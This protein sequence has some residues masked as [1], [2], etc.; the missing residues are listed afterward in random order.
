MWINTP[1]P[2]NS[3]DEKK[4]HSSHAFAEG[5]AN[6][7]EENGYKVNVLVHFSPYQAGD[8]NTIGKDNNVL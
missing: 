1:R 7:F 5:M 6:A 8:I 3:N 4:N 2:I